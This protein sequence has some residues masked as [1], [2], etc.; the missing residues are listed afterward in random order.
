MHCRLPGLCLY[1]TDADVF[2]TTES[3]QESLD[4]S[5]AASDHMSVDGDYDENSPGDTLPSKRARTASSSSYAEFI[6]GTA[7]RNAAMIASRSFCRDAIGNCYD[8][9][10]E[11]A[12][13]ILPDTR[14]PESRILG[15][16]HHVLSHRVFIHF[17]SYLLVSQ[18]QIFQYPLLISTPTHLPTIK[19]VHEKMRMG[20][21]VRSNR[22]CH[23]LRT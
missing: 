16:I 5:A 15:R 14:Y 6:S 11:H 7:S 20:F 2:N 10:R 18:N 3:D 21:R 22:V 9:I 8:I 12:A 4:N 13:L 1:D 19:L 23:S 17:L